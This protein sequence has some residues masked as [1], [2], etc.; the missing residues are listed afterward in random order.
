M[1]ERLLAGE[2]D[3]Y[4]GQAAGPGRTHER[5]G[6]EL[7]GLAG[8]RLWIRPDHPLAGRTRVS[9][10]ALG[11][12]VL[13]SG[14]AWNASVVPLLDDPR[15]REILT[16][17]IQ[18]DNFDLLVNVVMNSDA[19]IISAFGDRQQ[20]L[21]EL[22]VTGGLNAPPDQLFCFSLKG[23]DLSPAAAEA[24]DALKSRYRHLTSA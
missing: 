7:L 1:T 8:A 20:R 24:L 19:I 16:A 22:R 17:G 2:L 21:T 18:V 3:F 12:Y 23:I 13:A 9:L 10:E 11:D 6:Q 15:A 5:I 4:L 14:E